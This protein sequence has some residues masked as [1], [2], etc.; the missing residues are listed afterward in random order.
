MEKQMD[1]QR[2]ADIKIHAG[3]FTAFMGGTWAWI[4]ENHHQIGVLIGL[5]GLSYSIIVDVRRK[6]KL[7][8]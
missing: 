8:K 4:G 7:D 3:N 5:V 1:I 2:F 6:R